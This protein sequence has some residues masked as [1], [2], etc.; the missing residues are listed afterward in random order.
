MAPFLGQG[1][2]MHS[3]SLPSEIYARGGVLALL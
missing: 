3:A 2:R 1:T